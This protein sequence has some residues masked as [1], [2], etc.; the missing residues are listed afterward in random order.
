MKSP[1]RGRA[2]DVAAGGRLHFG[3]R[4]AGLPLCI[5]STV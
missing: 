3:F 2:M 4:V 1:N 5:G